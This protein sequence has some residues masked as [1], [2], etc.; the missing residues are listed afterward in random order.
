MDKVKYYIVGY[1][2]YYYNQFKS[3]K[4]GFLIRAYINWY[5]LKPM[6]KLRKKKKPVRESRSENEVH[7]LVQSRL[8]F[9]STPYLLS[10]IAKRAAN[11]STAE[12]LFKKLQAWCLHNGLIVRKMTTLGDCNGIGFEFQKPIGDGMRYANKRISLSQ[13]DN[14]NV[15]E[16]LDAVN[17]ELTWTVNNIRKN[18]DIQPK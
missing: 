10:G 1:W 11:V 9:Y 18:D 15:T 12:I 17:R 3:S 4:I 5:I 13:F 16:I 8:Q 2:M 14:S 6:K 7:D